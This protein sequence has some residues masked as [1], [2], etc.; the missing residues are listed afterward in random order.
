MSIVRPGGELATRPLHFI[1]VAD[2]ST[3]MKHNG[4]MEALNQAINDALPHMR[5]VAEENPNAEVLVRAIA[6]SSGAKWHVSEPVNIDYFEWNDLEAQG[7]TDMGAAFDLLSDALR[8]P[9]MSDRALPP[10]LVLISDGIPTDDYKASLDNL[11]KLPWGT[12]AVKL[13]IGI[14]RGANEKV[15]AEFINNKDIKV[16]KASNVDE[17]VEYIKWAS[18]VVLKAAS[19][20]ASQT[21][22][23]STITTNVVIPDLPDDFWD[24]MT[25]S[26]EDIW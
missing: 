15:L 4:K 5:R 25:V 11:L 10:V 23:I 24:S 1:W 12:K 6:F 18:T 19:S 7:I 8:M 22:E 2:C 21:E 9:P 26:V 17:L 20:P 14:G 3:S 16:L 13:G